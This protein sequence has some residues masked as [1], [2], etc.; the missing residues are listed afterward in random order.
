MRRYLIAFM[1]HRKTTIDDAFP[2]GINAMS[3][4]IQNI[5]IAF[6]PTVSN[7]M[8]A[9]IGDELCIF[10]NYF[11]LYGNPCCCKSILSLQVRFIVHFLQKK[12][13]NETI[14][15]SCETEKLNY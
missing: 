7:F 15:S 6:F 1:R 11:L 4:N 9:L 8:V 3:G 13:Q 5:F 14:I 12:E 10:E 2:Q